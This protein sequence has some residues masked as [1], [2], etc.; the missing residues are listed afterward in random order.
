MIVCTCLCVCVCVC[1]HSSR[2]V[3]VLRDHLSLNGDVLLSQWLLLGLIQIHINLHTK[4]ERRIK[5]NFLKSK[6]TQTGH[7]NS[8]ASVRRAVA[9][10]HPGVHASSCSV[11][12]PH[13][14]RRMSACFPA[15]PAS[16][17]SSSYW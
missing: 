15:R 3:Q 10:P 7:T 12:E 17:S 16:P 1:A 11:M 13:T 2:G 4:T 6:T 8:P 14:E 9:H 5:I